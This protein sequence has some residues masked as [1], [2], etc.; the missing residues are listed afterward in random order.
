MCLR[1]GVW[2]DMGNVRSKISSKR[3]SLGRER[4]GR[5]DREAAPQKLVATDDTI[6]SGST[7]VGGLM[8]EKGGYNDVIQRMETG[9]KEE[10]DTMRKIEKEV[11]EKKEKEEREKKEQEEQERELR[12]KN[13]LTQFMIGRF[14]SEKNVKVK[15]EKIVLEQE[16]RDKMTQLIEALEAAAL[17]Q[18]T[19]AGKDTQDLVR[20]ATDNTFSTERGE[21]VTKRMRSY[22]KLE[23]ASR[24]DPTK[25]VDESAERWERESSLQKNSKIAKTEQGLFSDETQKREYTRMAEELQQHFDLEAVLAAAGINFQKLIDEQPEDFLKLYYRSR[26]AFKGT[27]NLKRL[28]TTNADVHKAVRTSMAN[29]QGSIPANIRPQNVVK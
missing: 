22:R 19:A 11:R 9:R 3:N 1:E 24:V 29:L 20:R 15:K 26:E 8:I 25:G 18:K 21:L 2:G 5:S 17:E 23:K 4:S 16:T 14:E 12:E 28:Q 7:G 27:S 13:K 10:W 6:A